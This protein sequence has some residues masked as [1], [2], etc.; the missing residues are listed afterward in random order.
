[1]GLGEGTDYNGYCLFVCC[2]CARHF[3]IWYFGVFWSQNPFEEEL[4]TLFSDE[5]TK[6]Q[7]Y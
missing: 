6:A 2:N 5:E 1:M 3:L 4:L 7:R